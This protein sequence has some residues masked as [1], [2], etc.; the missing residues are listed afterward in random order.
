DI[1]EEL[2]SIQR[3]KTTVTAI[4]DVTHD[5]KEV[6]VKLIEPDTINFKAGQ[7]AQLVIPPYNAIKDI[8]MRAYSMLSTPRDSGQLGFLIRL[9]P[10]GIATT[11]VHTILKPGDTLD[12]IGPIGEFRLH[13][14]DGAMLCIAGGSGMAPIHSI[15]YDMKEKNNTGREVWFFFGARNLKELF[16]AERFKALEKEWPS[17]HFIPALSNPEP[18]DNWQGD[19]GLI[20]DVLDR[21]LKN[22]ISRDI[23]KQGYL[24][25]S[26]GMINACIKVLISNNVQ[27]NKIYYDKFA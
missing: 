18:E 11:Y 26:P 1:P 9:V 10:G 14:G 5:I 3:F 21:Y 20:T 23:S 4:K 8:N 24:C 22:Q 17:F 12:V 13:D 27:E 25:G 16:Y 15:I 2:F 19:S 7:Y 6:Y